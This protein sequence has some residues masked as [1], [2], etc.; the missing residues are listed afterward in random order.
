MSPKCGVLEG[1]LEER[2]APNKERYYWLKGE[3]T[4]PDKGEDT[5]EFA[6]S[7]GYASVVPTQFDLTAHHFISDLNTWKLS[8]EQDD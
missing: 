7:M 4:N 1:R 3:F 2:T 5:D 6:L 8:I